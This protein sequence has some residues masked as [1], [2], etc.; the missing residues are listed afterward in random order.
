QSALVDDKC[1][2]PGEVVLAKPVSHSIVTVSKVVTRN[3][4]EV[5]QTTALVSSKN[6]LMC[7]QTRVPLCHIDLSL[8]GPI[9]GT[10]H[11]IFLMSQGE[12]T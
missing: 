2:E 1:R 9:Q 8:V 12:E 6:L 3:A 11:L 5:K 10:S 4:G 7:S